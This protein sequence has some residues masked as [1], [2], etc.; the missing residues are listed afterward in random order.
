MMS[1]ILAV[2]CDL[3]LRDSMKEMA[4]DWATMFVPLVKAT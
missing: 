4:L 3:E 1:G 2:S